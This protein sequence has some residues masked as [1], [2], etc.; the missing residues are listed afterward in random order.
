M[1]FF[2]DE[3]ETLKYLVEV[4]KFQINDD[5]YE[6]PP[7][8]LAIKYESWNVIEYLIQKGAY[9]IGQNGY[10]NN[11]VITRNEEN[12]EIYKDLKT[13]KV[14]KPNLIFDLR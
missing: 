6:I 2:S 9:Y 5:T 14:I 3:I 13:K 12:K 10:S 1:T 11:L 4:Q 8:R 7:I